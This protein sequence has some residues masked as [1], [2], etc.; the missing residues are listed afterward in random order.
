MIAFKLSQYI[1]PCKVNIF[2]SW[3]YTNFISF[4]QYRKCF[5]DT[6]YVW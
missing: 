2:Y 1:N 5:C 6:F 3:V 4:A